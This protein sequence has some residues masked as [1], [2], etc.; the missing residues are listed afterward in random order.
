VIRIGLIGVS[1]WHAPLYYRALA[2]LPEA[3]V[4]AVSDPDPMVAARVAADLGAVARGDH[5]ALLEDAKPDFAFVFGRHCDMAHTAA[6]VIAAGV[7]CLIEKPGGLNRAEVAALHEAARRKGLHV[8]TA[9][10]FRVSDF[11][12]EVLALEE[13][14]T[15]AS[16]RFIAGAPDRYLRN[17][18]AWMLDP[19]LSGGGSTI[20]LSVH[21]F[22]LFSLFSGAPAGEVAALMGN[23]TWGLGIEDHSAVTLRSPRA[24]CSVQT[25]YTHP[26]HNG[27][28]DVGYQVRTR[29]HYV[30]AR[31]DNVIEIRN[32]KTADVR[33]VGTGSTGNGYWYPKLV[34][35]S[36]RRFSAGEAP[37]AGL[38]DLVAAM[39]IVDAAY[40]SSRAGGARQSS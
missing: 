7:P 39:T 9:F 37:V 3:R 1:H 30:N 35:E 15:W 6:D 38:G 13:P 23:H 4:T 25:G 29:N 36:L 17:G 21:F 19:S 33:R 32:L 10:S 34:E 12:R 5:R 2:R 40:A 18:C 24:V 11:A 26:G 8:G 22:D 27:A 20:N 16:F 28:W 14:A 31:S